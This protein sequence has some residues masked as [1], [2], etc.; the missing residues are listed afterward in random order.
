MCA[1]YFDEGAVAHTFAVAAG[2]DSMVV[3][4]NQILGQVKA[5]LTACQTHGTVGTVLNAL[6]QQALRVGKRVQTE[7][8]IGSAGRSLVTAAYELLEADLG[9][10]AGRRLLVLGAGSMAGL[11]A[12]TARLPGRRGDLREPDVRACS[13]TGRLSIGARA[14]PLAELTAALA[15]ADLLVACT[16]AR[17]VFVDAEQLKALARSSASSTWRSRRTCR[18]TSS[19]SASCWSTWPGWWPTSPTTPAG[20]RSRRLEPWSVAR[21]TTSSDCD[22]PLRSPRPSSPCARWR[23]RWSPPSWP[24]S[25]AGRRCSPS[26]SVTRCTG[27]SA[28]WWT[29]CS[30]SRPYGCRSWSADPESLDYAAALRELFALDPADRRG[31][32]VARRQ[33]G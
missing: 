14:R 7:T 11:A 31:G 21:S 6:F 9:S 25:T 17:D 29:S 5:A 22:G 30:T 16:G 12:R 8:E 3:G 4:E 2:L 20:R 10:I 19:S 23:R 33:G 28:G 27:P 15:E 13:A 1:V 24:A 26:G 18:A 32:H